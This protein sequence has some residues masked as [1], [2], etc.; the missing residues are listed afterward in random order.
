MDAAAVLTARL[1]PAPPECGTSWLN[2]NR[3]AATRHDKLAVRYEATVPHRRD[4]RTG[5]AP[6]NTP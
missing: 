6:A 1:S 2:R 5:S 4:Q 3:A